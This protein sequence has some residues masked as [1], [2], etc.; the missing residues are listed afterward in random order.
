MQLGMQ[1]TPQGVILSF[2]VTLTLDNA[3]ATQ[4]VKQ[5]LAYHPELVQEIAREALAQ[6]QQELQFLQMVRKSRND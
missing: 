4:F 3:A 1:V 6:K 2:P 5:F